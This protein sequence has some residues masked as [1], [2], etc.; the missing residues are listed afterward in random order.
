M[1]S[2]EKF[3]IFLKDACNLHKASSEKYRSHA[4]AV[5]RRGRLF[6]GSSEANWPLKA[7]LEMEGGIWARLQSQ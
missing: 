4:M 2:Q 3:K 7:R 1:F 5:S 6:Q